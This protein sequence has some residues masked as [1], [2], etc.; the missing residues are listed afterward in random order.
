MYK[1]VL[2]KII[3]EKKRFSGKKRFFRRGSLGSHWAVIEQSS[4]SNRAVMSL[5]SGNCQSSYNL[6]AVDQVIA[7]Q[8]LGVVRKLFVN[9]PEMVKKTSGN[10]Q[11][12]VRKLTGN[13]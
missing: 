12:I 2:V 9:C 6:H 4:G 1:F 10:C 5:F 13:C 7:M 11:E 3:L 8:S